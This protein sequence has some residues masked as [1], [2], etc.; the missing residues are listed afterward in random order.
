MSE[1]I[2]KAEL[3]AEYSQRP[4]DSK[5]MR[6]IAHDVRNRMNTIMLAND[7][8]PDELQIEE[9]DPL[10]YIDM[11]RRASEDIL[12]ILEAAVIAISEQEDTETQADT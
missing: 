8:L 1:H 10:K 12:I 3:I 5:Y 7:I 2:D 4:L 9:G 11:I 6:T